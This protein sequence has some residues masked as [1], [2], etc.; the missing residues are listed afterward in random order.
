MRIV[1]PLGIHDE[2][3]NDALNREDLTMNEKKEGNSEVRSMEGNCPLVGILPGIAQERGL[4]WQTARSSTHS[5]MFPSVPPLI[6]LLGRHPASWSLLA[7]RSRG[8][9]HLVVERGGIHTVTEDSLCG[10]HFIYVALFSNKTGLQKRNGLL[11]GHG[12]RPRQTSLK[13]L[14]TLP[15]SKHW[16]PI[17]FFCN[18]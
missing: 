5:A 1:A 6:P 9:F 13:T 14:P 12:N 4:S 15:S 17:L 3:R 2:R 16:K 8:L 11:T 10:R 18:T 7:K